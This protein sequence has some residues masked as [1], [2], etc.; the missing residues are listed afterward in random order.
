MLQE[1]GATESNPGET[2]TKTTGDS[3][4]VEFQKAVNLAEK[5]LE[6]ANT[7][8]APPY[9]KVY[10]VLYTYASGHNSKLND[11]VNEALSGDKDTGKPELEAIY[12]EV[13]DPFSS[14]EEMYF[15]VTS[16]MS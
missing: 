2:E 4:Q 9:P 15:S 14:F 8:L 13:L 10:E 6:M 16:E 3:K 7:H 5:T 12:N 1:A 11:L